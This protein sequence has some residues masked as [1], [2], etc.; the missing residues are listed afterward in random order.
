[1][2]TK[3]V[4]YDGDCV[5]FTTTSH[6]ELVK[7]FKDL[8]NPDWQRAEDWDNRTWNEVDA[9]RCFVYDDRRDIWMEMSGDLLISNKETEEILEE[10]WR[11]HQPWLVSM[12]LDIKEYLMLN[13][14][15]QDLW[16][17]GVIKWQ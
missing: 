16:I 10:D 15:Y 9:I 12:P 17:K 13:G 2:N 4:V 5:R 7:Y 8:C 6:S 3:R 14:E 11:K 1:M